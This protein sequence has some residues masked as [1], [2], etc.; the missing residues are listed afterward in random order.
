MS[1]IY[2]SRMSIECCSHSVR[3]KNEEKFSTYSIFLL[4]ACSIEALAIV[5]NQSLHF[6]LV[7]YKNLYPPLEKYTLQFLM[8]IIKKKSV[9]VLLLNKMSYLIQNGNLKMVTR[10]SIHIVSK[11]PFLIQRI[12]RPS[13][14]NDNTWV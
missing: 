3:L 7:F 2:R 8:L 6:S 12:L 4:H 11:I 14:R 13:Q 10:V 5:S 1:K 9:A